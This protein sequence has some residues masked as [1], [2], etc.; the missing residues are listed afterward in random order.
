MDLMA[1]AFCADL[2]LTLKVQSPD[3]L[4][5]MTELVHFIENRPAQHLSRNCSALD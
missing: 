5:S 4:T 2:T 3:C 1:N